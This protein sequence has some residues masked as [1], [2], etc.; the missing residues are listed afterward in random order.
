[1]CVHICVD[2]N[3]HT[4]FGP[5][6]VCNFLKTLFFLSWEYCY[7]KHISYAE[8]TASQQHKQERITVF[9]S[10][11]FQGI[12]AKCVWRYL[13]CPLLETGLYYGLCR[14][15]LISPSLLSS[16]PWKFAC[17]KAVLLRGTL[18][19]CWSIPS[20][21]HSFLLSL[22]LSVAGI[23]YGWVTTMLWM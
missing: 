8:K 6:L 3:T 7:L 17:V 4:W 21:H 10:S 20:S 18:W 14:S 13:F 12:W 2:I 15:A 19:N 22:C 9:V 1:M 11:I 23:A 5:G 16:C